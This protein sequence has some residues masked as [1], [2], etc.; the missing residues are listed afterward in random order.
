M[1]EEELRE[2]IVN[3]IWLQIPWTAH[4]KRGILYAASDKILSLIR[5]AGWKSPEDLKK[6][7]YETEWQREVEKYYKE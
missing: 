4:L 7:N 5:E 6:Q 3:I 2:K 1:T